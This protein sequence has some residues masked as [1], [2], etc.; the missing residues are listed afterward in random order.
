MN[1]K[2]TVFSRLGR[3]LLILALLGATGAHWAALQSVAW[4]TMLADN[5]RSADFGE[6][7][8]KTFDGR[9]PCKLCK[10]V[11]AGRQSEKKS[12]MQSFGARLEFVNKLAQFSFLGP[13]SCTLMPEQTFTGSS[14]SYPP[15][16]PPPRASA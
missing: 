16:V 6:A 4:A 15:P 5:A 8:V 3:L 11:A 12:P 2:D 1:N 14:T 9:H 13:Q 7:L 10:Q